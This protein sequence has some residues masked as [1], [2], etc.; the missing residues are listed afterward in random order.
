M[1]GIKIIQ[2]FVRKIFAANISWLRKNQL[3]NLKKSHKIHF[4]LVRVEVKRRQRAEGF[5]PVGKAENVGFYFSSAEWRDLPNPILRS[6]Y[7]WVWIDERS[8]LDPDTSPIISFMIKSFNIFYYYPIYFLLIFYS[9]WI[10]GIFDLNSDHSLL[11]G[12][13]KTHNT[14]YCQEGKVRR[15]ASIQLKPRLRQMRSVAKA[16]Q[17]F[18]FHR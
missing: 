10:L 3:Q 15:R 12:K 8:R 18:I 1:K 2:N 13:K 11:F 6:I 9:N 17:G 5:D 16:R 7:T 14:F 4:F